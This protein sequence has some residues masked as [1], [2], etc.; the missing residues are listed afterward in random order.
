M[1]TLTI[2]NSYSNLSGL[3]ITQENRIRDLLSYTPGSSGYLGR[4]RYRI[5]RK[6]CLMDKKGNFPSGLLYRVASEITHESYGMS[7]NNVRDLRKVP[8]HTFRLIA[9]HPGYYDWQLQ[10]LKAVSENATGII[11]APTGTGKSKVIGMI[12]E[13]YGLRTLVIVPTLE[14]KRQLADNLKHLPN[15]TVDN[16][17]SNALNDRAKAYD[18]LIID[19]AHRAAAKT[20]HRLN[21]TV[22]TNIYFRYFT[23]ATPFRT[24]VE[25]TLLF[26]AI[27]G[28]LIYKLDYQT[29]VKN[30][31]IVPVEAYYYQLPKKQTDAYVWAEVYSSLITINHERNMEISRVLLN[32]S[33]NQKSTLCLVKQVKHG[34]TLSDI[35]GLPFVSGEDDDSRGYIQEF[36][37]GRQKVLIA[38]TGIMGEGIDSRPC[39]Y[40]IIAGLGKAKS[41]FM[42]QVGRGVRTYPDKESAKVVLFKDPS[43][44]FTLRHFREQVKILKEEYGVTP[45]KLE[46]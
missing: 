26:E 29:A 27:T 19:E 2:N 10:A 4:N 31:Y 14:I 37:E 3:S 35:T 32:L 15:V 43:H 5:I 9:K 1:I 28:Q 39:E 25:E 22:W 23:T 8:N 36:N 34:K 30:K 6:K 42:Q 20:Y 11:C 12:A 18:V 24:N 40:V 7:S 46:F 33:L 21:R 17:D 44:K 45:T 16:I 38:T 41:Q 13:A